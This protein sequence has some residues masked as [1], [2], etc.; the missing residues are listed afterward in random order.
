[1]L[2]ILRPTLEESLI[3][4]QAIQ[5]QN[6]SDEIALLDMPLKQTNKFQGKEY[7][8]EE[9]SQAKRSRIF[10]NLRILNT[11]ALSGGGLIDYHDA[12]IFIT[13][14]IEFTSICS[15]RGF[16]IFASVKVVLAKKEHMVD[17]FM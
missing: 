2:E 5:R 4:F 11:T 9:R 12:V 16:A 17:I 15:C 14:L 1:M 13:D 6:R 8:K 7:R 3:L 10:R